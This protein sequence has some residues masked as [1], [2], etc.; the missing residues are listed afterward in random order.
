[1]ET[2]SLNIDGLNMVYSV[3][4][5]K[6][7]PPLIMI[8]GW[9][10]FKGVWR[11]TIPAL[12][13]H[14]RCIAVDLIGCG[15]SDIPRHANVTIPKQAERVKALVDSLGYDKVSII[16]HSMGGQIALYLA[17]QLIPDRIEKLVN[18]A[19]VAHAKLTKAAERDL[20]TIKLAQ[21]IPAVFTSSR[22]WCHTR[23]YARLFCSHW[24]YD[25]DNPD[26]EFWR[27]DR[28]SSLRPKSHRVM[29][30]AWEAI[31]ACDLSDH[32]IKITAPTLTIFGKQDN[33]VPI[34]SGYIADEHIPNH[35]LILID[36]C[37]HFAMYEQTE[38]Y[39]SVLQA[40]L[41]VPQQTEKGLDT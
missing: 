2:H 30:S 40:F 33:V 41:D 21:Y 32:L 12:K 37:G 1:M 23:L 7:A 26:V 8:H 34:E 13:E 31:T 38:T 39:L 36:K 9:G 24:L 6:S 35:Q 14:Y 4:G 17:S 15:E 28:Y 5:D 10:S 29:Y 27:E 18:V 22:L 16:G 3:D 19:G 11:T 20:S 25:L